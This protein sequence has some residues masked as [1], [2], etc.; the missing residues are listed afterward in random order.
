MRGLKLFPIEKTHRA[1]AFEV[2][3][4]LVFVFALTRI[5]ALMA[6]EPTLVVLAQG[7]VLMLLLWWLFVTY[8]WLANQAPADVGVMRAGGLV[9]MTAIFVVAFEI[10]DVWR[11][12]VQSVA[13]PLTVVV[14]YIVIRGVFLALG[15]R[16]SAGD[17]Q[18]R[19]R[20]LRSAVPAAHRTAQPARA[21]HRRGRHP[22]AAPR[23]PVPARPG[24]ARPDHR[25][26]H[27]PHPL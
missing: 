27:R 23:R 6:P 24:R 26:A 3:F 17:N 7:F 20:L 14:A 9:V 19:R 25:H 16:V 11:E 10:P 4:D 1:T 2:F 12:E 13:A 21:R 18:L 22:P 8:C 15:M 5:I